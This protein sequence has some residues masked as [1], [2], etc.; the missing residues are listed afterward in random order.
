M[1]TWHQEQEFLHLYHDIEGIE[2]HLHMM[3]RIRDNDPEK[4][5]SMQ[6][7]TEKQVQMEEL[8]KDPIFEEIWQAKRAGRDV[9]PMIG[10]GCSQQY[11]TDLLPFTVLDVVYSP[12]YDPEEIRYVIVQGDSWVNP[13]GIVRNPEGSV[14][15]LRQLKNGSWA[16]IY[17]SFPTYSFGFRHKHRPMED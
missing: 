9:K 12:N 13:G 2:I 14:F 3:Q 8:R 7:L 10:M 5:A 6:E 16:T 4:V 11:V 17:T 15:L 1:T